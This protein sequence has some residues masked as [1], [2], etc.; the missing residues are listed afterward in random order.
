MGPFHNALLFAFCPLVPTAVVELKKKKREEE[1]INEI[2]GSH[3]CS[4]TI[5][6]NPHI[7]LQTQ[8][9]WLKEKPFGPLHLLALGLV[10]IL[11]EKTESES[12]SK[13]HG[14]QSGVQEWVKS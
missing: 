13:Q 12:T 3:P 10:C 14:L 11:K 8:E 1:E 5:L 4:D 6:Y 2:N 9:M 7:L